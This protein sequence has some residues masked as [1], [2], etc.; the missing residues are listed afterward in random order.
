MDNWLGLAWVSLVLFYLSSSLAA[1]CFV[2][3]G[4]SFCLFCRRGVCVCII[5]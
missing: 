1:C 2:I 4:D 3:P 5:E